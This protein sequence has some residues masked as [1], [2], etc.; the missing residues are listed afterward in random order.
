MEKF[1]QLRKIQVMRSSR[2]LHDNDPC[3]MTSF[4][5]LRDEFIDFP[6]ENW[7]VEL[8]GNVWEWKK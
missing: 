5:V 8:N 2:I 7:V 3:S 6:E 1:I 4:E